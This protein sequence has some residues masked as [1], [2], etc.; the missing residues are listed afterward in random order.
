MW[1]EPTGATGTVAWQMLYML[2]AGSGYSA[3]R[4]GNES[5]KGNVYGDTHDVMG[6][7]RPQGGPWPMQD[8]DVN[9]PQVRQQAH[10]QASP[11]CAR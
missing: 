4:P 9:G 3:A 1:G 6:A 2:L 5:A 11:S 7:S 10:R 8:S